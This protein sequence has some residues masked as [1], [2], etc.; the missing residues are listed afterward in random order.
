MKAFL[1]TSSLIKLYHQEEG[2]DFVVEVL[3][4]DVVEIFLSE[5][6]VLEFRAALWKKIREKEIEEKVAI[7]VIKCFQNDV[8]N[9]QWILLQSDLVESASHLLMNYGIRGLRTLDSLELEAAL[10]LRDEE[11][12]FLTSDKLLRT[13]FKDELLKVL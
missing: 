3:S 12:V 10:T 6:A 13:L 11:C 1:D 2:S 4:N 7:E 8:N 5:L 9:F